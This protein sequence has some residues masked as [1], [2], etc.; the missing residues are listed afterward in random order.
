MMPSNLFAAIPPVLT[1]E[2]IEPLLET[3]SFR[4]ERIVSA[5]QVTP[6]GEWYDQERCE[7]V[8]LLSGGATLRFEDEAEPV[9]L[10]PGDHVLMAAHRRH[11]VEWTDPA[12][13][14]VWLALHYRNE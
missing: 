3:A 7:W 4:L 10:R 1:Q 13:K 8:V 14:T 6:A 12:Q 11:R 5:G 9:S 2:L